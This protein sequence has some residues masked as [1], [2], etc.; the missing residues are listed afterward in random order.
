MKPVNR[1]SLQK[2]WET[3]KDNYHPEEIIAF[4]QHN[5][6]K[7]EEYFVKLDGKNRLY[8]SVNAVFSFFSFLARIADQISER[9]QGRLMKF[10]LFRGWILKARGLK[11]Q[12]NFRELVEFGRAKLYSLRLPPQNEKTIKLLEEIMEFGFK[13]GYDFNQH[14]PNARQKVREMKNQFLQHK[15]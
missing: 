1:L 15:F 3:A 12:L 11:N 4:L 2:W 13:H 14:F 8:N 6:D 10:S 9:I 7:L 5:K